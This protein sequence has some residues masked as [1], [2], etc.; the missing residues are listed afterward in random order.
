[1]PV[2][3]PVANLPQ[4]PETPDFAE[5]NANAAELSQ[6]TETAATVAQQVNEKLRGEPVTV[7]SSTKRKRSKLP[8]K[9]PASAITALI[10]TREQ[11]PL[12]L[13]ELR[14]ERAT[15]AT[16][17]YSVRGMETIIA[18]ERKSLPDL[19]GVCG[20][21][22]ERFE[23]E[24]MRLL[25]FPVRA[26]VIEADWSDIERGEWRSQITPK[27]VGA[28]LIAWQVRGLPVVM[29]GNHHRAAGLVASMLRRAT[30]DRYRALRELSREIF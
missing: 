30:L 1:M 12:I 8:A 23:R 22:R 29:A 18:I 14:T 25:A 27:A 15:L 16:G 5:A 2:P 6:R 17:D 10:D 7:A 28:S 9:L 24:I 26:L 20:R 21:D 13:P 4:L 19:L 11:T 3:N